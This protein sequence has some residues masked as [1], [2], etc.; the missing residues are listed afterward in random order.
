[1]SEERRQKADCLMAD[2]FGQTRSQLHEAMHEWIYGKTQG[3]S[4]E[5]DA[6]YKDTAIR[7]RCVCLSTRQQKGFYDNQ[8]KLG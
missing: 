7:L 6:R 5:G 4:A 8:T 3:V 2:K 1:M